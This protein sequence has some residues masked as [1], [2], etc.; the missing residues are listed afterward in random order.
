[1]VVEEV[2]AADRLLPTRLSMCLILL[3]SRYHV[4]LSLKAYRMD[5]LL[6]CRSVGNPD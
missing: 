6:L 5:C 1:M 2:A 3:M 4:Y